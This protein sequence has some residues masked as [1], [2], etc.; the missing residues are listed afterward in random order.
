A[1]R[2]SHHAGRFASL[3]H[4][5]LRSKSANLEQNYNRI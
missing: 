3:P 1:P 5:T 2:W 4:L